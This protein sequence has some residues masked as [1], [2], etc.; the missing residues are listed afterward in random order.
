MIPEGCRIF[1]SENVYVFND[2]AARFL[3][4][5][6][7]DSF[8]YPFETDFEIL[9]SMQHKNGIVPVY[10][11]PE[12]FFSRM[13]VKMENVESFAGNDTKSRYRRFRKNGATI[14][15][16]DKAVS[17]LQHKNRLKANGFSS[18]LIDVTWDTLSKNRLK[19]LKTRFLKSEQIQPTTSFNFT[20]GLV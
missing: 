16:P 20:K 9:E 10:F 17:I 14:I 6:G 4:N 7:V 12:L 11:F 18:F 5:E 2:A 15:V 8:I 3:K 1:T 13:P 19:T